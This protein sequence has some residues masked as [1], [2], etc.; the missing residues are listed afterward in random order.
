MLTQEAIQKILGIEEVVHLEPSEMALHMNVTIYPVDHASLSPNIKNALDLLVSTLKK[1][2]VQFTDFENAF[3][4]VP[5]KKRVRRLFKFILNNIIWIIRHIL[6][7]KQQSF[8]IDLETIKSLTSSKKFIRNLCIIVP[9]EIPASE[10]PMLKISNFKDN[11]IISVLD[12]P[13]N[14]S[15]RT[16]FQTHFDT[17]MSLF[18]H[19]MTNIVIAADD[20]KWMIYNYNASHPIFNIDSSDF[21]KHIMKGLIPKVVAPISPHKY[22]EFIIKEE[23]FDPEEGVHKEIITDIIEGSNNLSDKNLF[24]KGKQIDDLPFRKNFHKLI[25]KMHLDNRSGMSFGFLAKQMPTELSRLN[26]YNESVNTDYFFDKNQHLNIIIEIDSHKY[27]LKVPDVWV[28]SIKS[29]ANKTHIKPREDLL[30]LG[31][32]NGKMCIQLPEG[33]KIDSTYKPSFDTKVI[34]AHAVGNAITASISSHLKINNTHVDDITNNGM[35]MIHWHGYFNNELIPGGIFEYGKDNPHVACSSPQ[36]AIYALDGKL[37]NFKQICL[38]EKKNYISDIHV[39]PHHGSNVN[40]SSI[41]K[42][43]EYLSLH[44]D[45]VALGNKYL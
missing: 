41:I 24:P 2:K 22:S 25:G 18:A 36:S 3:Q 42:F 13:A 35:G 23:R 44:P 4:S 28:M 20:K 11:S 39:E 40:F 7:L 37:R 43:A 27:S 26:P 32:V 29:G 12:F 33:L 38:S 16:D 10:L 5:F 15:E 21:E 45:A 34:L 30:K 17:A 19:H 9:G 8:Y 14:I 1:N 6:H 31:L